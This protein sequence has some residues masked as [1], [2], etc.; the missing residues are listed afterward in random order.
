MQNTGL[1]EHVIIYFAGASGDEH[2]QPKVR[3]DP[4]QQ[5]SISDTNAL[6]TSRAQLRQRCSGVCIPLC[7]CKAEPSE[8]LCVVPC[9]T[10]TIGKHDAQDELSVCF[11]LFSSSS[12]SN[13]RRWWPRRR[14][15]SRTA[16]RL[17]G[18]CARSSLFLVFRQL[19]IVKNCHICDAP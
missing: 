1:G 16:L 7:C 4:L 11:P 14:R 12:S 9:N 17:G 6:N 15:T 10:S 13:C 2:L 5:N 3:A 8:S 18:F 19:E